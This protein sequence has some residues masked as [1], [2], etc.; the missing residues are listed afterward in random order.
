MGGVSSHTALG[1]EAASDPAV[2]VSLSGRLDKV[3]SMHHEVKDLSDNQ[4][5]EKKKE[6]NADCVAGEELHAAMM[7]TGRGKAKCMRHKDSLSPSNK[8]NTAANPSVHV[9]ST[10]DSHSLDLKSSK[11]TCIIPLS[12][13]SHTTEAVTLIKEE[14]ELAQKFCETIVQSTAMSLEL[15]RRGI[16]ATEHAI[17]QQVNFQNALL[18]VLA[19][20]FQGTR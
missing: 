6:K 4:C 14:Q 13:A 16:E 8:E 11:C 17:Q 15:Q 2:F 3:T 10:S 20:G 18:E 9:Q 5:E 1:C 7:K 12:H 19:H